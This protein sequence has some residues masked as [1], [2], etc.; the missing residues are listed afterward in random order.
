MSFKEKLKN[1]IA[2]DDELLEFSEDEVQTLS[3][4]EQPRNSRASRVA[5]DTK[6]VIFEPRSFEETRDIATHIKEGR[7]AVVN[8]HR[9]QKDYSQRCIDFLT[10]VI[11]ALDGEII[12]VDHSVIVCTPIS[13][14]V[15]GEVNLDED[16][17]Y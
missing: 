17:D 5:T 3:E 8:L 6:M 13:I 7:A 1:F 15:E 12:K 10:G 4:Y 14:M 16:S 11:F 2:P 9:L